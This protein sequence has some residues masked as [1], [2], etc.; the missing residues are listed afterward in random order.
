MPNMGPQKPKNAY[1][2]N[3][4]KYA[5]KTSEHGH[6]EP[7]ITG[8]RYGLDGSMA[9]FTTM[10]WVEDNR[11]FSSTELQ[12]EVAQEVEQELPPEVQLSNRAASANAATQAYEDVLLNRQGD[13]AINGNSSPVEDYKNA[14]Q[15]NLTEE[16][17]AKAPTTLANKRAEIEMADKQKADMNDSYEL[18]L[19][20][21]SSPQSKQGKMIFS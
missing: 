21:V 6:Y 5:K 17:K 8:K 18:N 16:L 19:S 11:D 1:Q 15:N 10:N 13:A 3:N 20:S 2:Y 12:P 7:E 14:Y 9:N 4:T